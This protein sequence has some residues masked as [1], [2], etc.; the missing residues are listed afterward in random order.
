MRDE[1]YSHPSEQLQVGSSRNWSVFREGFSTGHHDMAIFRCPC[2]R[3]TA[4]HGAP[5]TLVFMLGLNEILDRLAMAN[6]DRWYGLVLRREDGHAL[7]R[8]LD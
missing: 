2:S 6:S 8:A 4:L 7:R 5:Q 3:L 1:S